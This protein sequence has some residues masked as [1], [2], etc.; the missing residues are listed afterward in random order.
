MANSP[1]IFQEAVAH[2]LKLPIKS[3][4]H[5]YHYINDLVMWQDKQRDQKITLDNLKKQAITTLQ[6]KGFRVVEDPTTLSHH[7]QILTSIQSAKPVTDVPNPL[8]L[9]IFQSFLGS[10]TWLKS[11]L[12]IPTS[13]LLPLFDLKGDKNHSFPTPWHQ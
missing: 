8:T 5:I 13:Q 4:L 12:P 2:G 1:T 11:W 3:G 9:N 6:E 7:T 10:V